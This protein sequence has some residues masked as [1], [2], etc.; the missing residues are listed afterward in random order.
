VCDTLCVIGRDRTLFA[1]N[2]D[3]PVREPQ[4]V[5]WHARRAGGGELRTQY[6]TLPDTGAHALL[7]SRPTWLWGLEHGVNEH[8][9]A[10]GN[11]KVWTVD[12]AREVPPALL[13]MDLVR[14]GLERATTADEALDVMTALLERHGQGGSGE[15]DHD[16]PYFSSFLVADPAGA[17]VLETSARTWAARRVEDG[18]AISNRLAL[19]TDWDRA[20]ADVPAGADFD[21]WRNPK[22]PTG[23]ADHRL[24]VTSRVVATSRVVET[25]RAVAAGRAMATGATAFGPHDIV[26][27][28]RH[29]GTEAWGAPGEPGDGAVPPPDDVGD[30]W[31]GVTVC[32]H[33]RGYQTTTASMLVELERDPTAPMRAWAC[34]GSPCTGVYVPLFPPALPAPLADAAQWERFARLRDRVEHEPSALLDIRAVLGPV[35]S[36]LWD[37]ADDLAS[38]AD[39][40]AR[41]RFA[42]RA[43]QPVDAAL[44]RLA[45]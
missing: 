19:R 9:V 41:Q 3:R 10:I 39:D 6:L 32:M 31:S 42:V 25:G 14:L 37:E 33:V 36:D 26:A 43:W 7:G 40:A 24:R 20:S 12:D 22:A 27:T 28:L 18:A 29:H 5:E 21:A 34:L 17:W 23:I 1:K 15:A 44:A 16:E 8:R 4:V 11:E 13:G 45:V 38:G 35:E 30:D 2:S